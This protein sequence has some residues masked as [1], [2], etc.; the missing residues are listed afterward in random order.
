MSDKEKLDQMLNN[1]ID[2]NNEQ[3]QVDFH[4]YLRGKM[5]TSLGV[6]NPDAAVVGTQDQANSNK[7]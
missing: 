4:Q 6:V 1:L 5:Q 7:E 2:D 3:A